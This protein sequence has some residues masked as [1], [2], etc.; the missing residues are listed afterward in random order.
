MNP[1]TQSQD[2]RILQ[3]EHLLSLLRQTP[4]DIASAKAELDSSIFTPDD[5]AHIADL[6][7]ADSTFE[8]QEYLDTDPRPTPQEFHGAYLP[9]AILLLLEAGLNPNAHDKN[10]DTCLLHD[11]IYVD[12][13]NAA[14]TTMRYLL[15]YGG[16]PN[17]K[18][19]GE[20]LFSKLDFMVSYDCVGIPHFVQCLF[21]L[22]AFGGNNGAR[23]IPFTMKNDY[24][25]AR[26]KD[27]E[28]IAYSIESFGNCNWIMHICDS[29]AGAEIAVYE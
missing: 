17:L 10:A 5:L 27:F 7:I 4:P 29:N 16:D 14:A 8:Y 26:L 12:T 9:D 19:C 24:D 20:P 22:A 13:P 3:K 6:L 25:I 2:D 1:H 21:V 23:G 11:L 18:W 28:S 15:E